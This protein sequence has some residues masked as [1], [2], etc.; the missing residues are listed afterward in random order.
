[1]SVTTK[2]SKR[3]AWSPWRNRALVGAAALASAAAA[4]GAGAAHA[5]AAT[6]KLLSNN[7]PSRLIQSTGNL[8]WTSDSRA[9][10]IGPTGLI[11]VVYTGHVWRASKS[12]VPGQERQLYSESQSYPVDFESI[13]WALVG[14]Q[15]YGYFV[16][17][18]PSLGISQIKRVPLAGGGA[19]TLVTSPSN[20]GSRDL[21]N[22]GAFLYWADARAVRRMPIGGG[23][24]MVLVSGTTFSRVAVDPAKVFYSAGNTI[25]AVPKTGGT[26][27][28]LVTAASAISAMA[29]NDQW[30]Y[31]ELVYGET[32]GSVIENT[33]LLP[34]DT[35]VRVVEPARAGYAITTVGMN[36]GVGADFGECLYG[37]SCDIDGTTPTGGKPVDVQGDGSSLFWGS[38]GLYSMA[39][40][41][42]W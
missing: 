29:L 23:T 28:T 19:T 18:Y 5:T 14:G 26:P 10:R 25:Q 16:A 30:G 39:D 36:D 6:P 22:D 42:I 27:T 35:T 24:P 12:N 37:T 4:C 9:F 17:N 41:I 32:N 34:N 13:T 21:V 1:M 11:S 20:I 15:Y 38:N 7:S 3:A 8:Y 33:Y 2:S 31:D 40:Q